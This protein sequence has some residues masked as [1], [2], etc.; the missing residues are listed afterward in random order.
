MRCSAAVLFAATVGIIPNLSAQTP[1]PPWA[2]TLEERIALRSNPQLARER[3]QK[4]KSVKTDAGATLPADSFDGRDHPE[5]F[6]PHQVFRTLMSLAFVRGEPSGHLFRRALAPDVAR[7][8]LPG[9]FWERLQ[10]LSATHVRNESAVN[11]LMARAQHL[12]AEARKTLLDACRSGSEALAAAREEFG[13]EPF[14]RFLY[15]VIVVHMFHFTD[16]LPTADDLRTAA[17]ACR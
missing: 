4:D 7:L 14:D 16:E 5:L 17:R 3:V 11:D 10:A 2:F 8:G 6:L 13:A 15:E 1:K 12:D 9:D